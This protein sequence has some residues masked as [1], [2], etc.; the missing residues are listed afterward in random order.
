MVKLLD[1][2]R[3]H[4]ELEKLIN[5]KRRDP[6]DESYDL[7][8]R[9]QMAIQCNEKKVS[10]LF[11]WIFKN[12]TRTRSTVLKT[13]REFLHLSRY[14]LKAFLTVFFIFKV[15][16]MTWWN[17]EKMFLILFA[18]LFFSLWLIR[19]ASRSWLAFGTTTS[20]W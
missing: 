9:L 10:R 20:V 8:A 14:H 1:K 16:L 12:C 3:G 4:D 5:K 19:A 15:G 2:V 13:R 17:G 6:R 18:K 7:L 11:L